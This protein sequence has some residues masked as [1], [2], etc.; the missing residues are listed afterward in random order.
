MKIGL[1]MSGG[2]ARGISHVG[3]IKGLEE[4][5]VKAQVVAG[6]SAG[7][8][9]GSLYA[10]GYSPDKILTEILALKLFR[11]MRPAWTWTGLLSLEALASSLS[12]LMP[13]NDFAKLKI[14]LSVAATDI[15]T[16]AAKYFSEGELIP[17][18]LSSCCIPALFN[19]IQFNG[20]LYVDGGLVDN[21]PAASI[22]DKC[23]LL[24][25][26][27]CN[28]LNSDFDL[29]NMRSVVERTVLIAINV[30]AKLSKSQ[31]DIVIE[32][33][34]VGSYSGMDISKARELFESGYKFVLDNFSADDFDGK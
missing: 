12:T 20:G 11:S 5:G 23:D 25:G 10:Y 19:P 17:A 1:V 26:S 15:R 8:I 21:L 31:C 29:K 7:S 13:E 22:R 9:V 14:P 24:I 33:P 34:M 27:H 18:V 2:G 6:T 28:Y 4:L 16:G 30:N 32:P 3:V